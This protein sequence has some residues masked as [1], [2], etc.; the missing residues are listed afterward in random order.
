MMRPEYLIFQ[1]SKAD[2]HDVPPD[3]LDS[4][5]TNTRFSKPDRGSGS[6]ITLFE[7]STNPRESKTQAQVKFGGT[8]I[9]EE[10]EDSLVKES[11]E[12]NSGQ[13]LENCSDPENEE[14]A[15]N[16]MLD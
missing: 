12:R 16:T 15:A 3:G 6:E 1:M 8:V 9:I 4:A 13:Y 2:S 10:D 11:Q 14:R 7:V 5:R